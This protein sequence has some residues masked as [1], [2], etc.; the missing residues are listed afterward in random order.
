[1]VVALVVV[2]ILLFESRRRPT[3]SLLEAE[4]S[5]DKGLKCS[6]LP[7][8]F[9]KISVLCFHKYE[10]LPV[11]VWRSDTGKTRNFRPQHWLCHD[12][13]NGCSIKAVMNF[14]AMPHPLKVGSE[15]TITGLEK[16]FLCQSQNF[17]GRARV[18]FFWSHFLSS[19]SQSCAKTQK[20]RRKKEKLSLRPASVHNRTQTLSMK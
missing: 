9:K 14:Q 4:K 11:I 15:R 2:E 18:P 5:V 10:H 3:S 8:S 6:V 16:S 1:M 7:I 20:F 19:W 12:F 13:V 17:L